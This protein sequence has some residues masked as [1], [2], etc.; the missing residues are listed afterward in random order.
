MTVYWF[1]GKDRKLHKCKVTRYRLNAYI[2]G[3]VWLDP[4]T[5]PRCYSLRNTEFLHVSNTEGEVRYRN[6]WLEEEDDIKAQH[7]YEEYFLKQQEELLNKMK[8]LSL[9]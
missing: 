6:F 7:I 8:N 2:D 9:E 4:E 5:D 3:T 1:N